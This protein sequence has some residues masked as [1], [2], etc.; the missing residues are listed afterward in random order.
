MIRSVLFGLGL[1]SKLASACAEQMLAD[2]V[3]AVL[4]E[5][6]DI[7]HRVP[8]EGRVPIVDKYSDL[9]DRTTNFVPTRTTFDQLKEYVF[10]KDEAAIQFETALEEYE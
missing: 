4:P 3:P 8:L 7:L 9:I 10:G 2:V 5:V 6:E 1:T